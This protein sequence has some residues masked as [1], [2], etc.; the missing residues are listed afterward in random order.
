MASNQVHWQTG[1]TDKLVWVNEQKL[2]IIFHTYVQSHNQRR[3]ENNDVEK[4]EE[5]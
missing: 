1:Q 2:N 4:Q 3:K 5:Q